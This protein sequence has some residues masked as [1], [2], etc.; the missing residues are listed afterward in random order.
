MER[1]TI[2]AL[3]AAGGVNVETIR[4]Y[5]R[6]GLLPAPDR[7][8]AG[9]RQYRAEDLWRLGF[10]RRAKGLGFTLAEIAELL[11]RRSDSVVEVL[12][13]ARAKLAQV[14]ADIAGLVTL[15]SNLQRLVQTCE[16][17]DMADCLDLSLAPDDPGCR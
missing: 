15:R 3:A 11:G 2:G 10:I 1:L 9:Y 8:G 4:Y 5:E 13:A 14:E 12:A 6:R 7:S 17:G 16:T